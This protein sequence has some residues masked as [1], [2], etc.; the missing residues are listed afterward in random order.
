[1][2][3]NNTF[4][5]DPELMIQEVSSGKIVSA[6]RILKGRDKYKPISLGDGMKCYADN[7]LIEA[8]FPPYKS[9]EE[10][11]QGF[12]VA[13][14]RMQEQVGANHRILSKAA[15]VYDDSELK[16]KRAREAGCSPNFDVYRRRMNKSPEFDGG[17]R[18][19][20]GHIHL[21][22]EKLIDMS[23]KEEAIKLI[24]IYAGCASIIFDKDE[25]A[26]MRRRLYGKAGE[27]RPTEY[28]CEYR[29]LSNW[30]LRTPET[31]KLVLDLVS[32]AM[33][34]LDAGTGPDVLAMVN[35]DDVEAAINNND[36]SLART[37]LK[38]VGL[39]AKL[40]KRIEANYVAPE[41][42]AAWGVN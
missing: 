29:P 16:D 34:H 27:F 21:G 4:G 25:T 17:M 6:L 40:F 42:M 23:G 2:K 35:S 11:I 3:I 38:K 15:H 1:M 24:D 9:A 7:V 19:G 8:S 37:L 22:H 32:Y 10:M 31:T 18:T 41:T 33:D 14:A 20:S 5:S 30:Y 12:R 36:I 39:P 13:F 28:G 26:P